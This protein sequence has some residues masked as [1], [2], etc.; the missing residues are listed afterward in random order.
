MPPSHVRCDHSL[1]VDCMAC[2]LH[3]HIPSSFTDFVY[4]AYFSGVTP[5]TNHWYWHQLV[6]ALDSWC[7][8][9]NTRP[10]V[11]PVAACFSHTG[12]TSFMFELL[13]SC[14]VKLSTFIFWFLDCQE[15]EPDS[16]KWPNIRPE[17]DI[18]Y[19]LTVYGPNVLP[20]I[21]PTL[22]MH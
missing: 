9:S 18:Q 22:S 5:V 15:P 12:V 4:R 14:K 16:E 6:L 21:R 8:H 10:V 13:M 20:V 1:A 19:I 7:R 17:L 11:R 2:T 3:T